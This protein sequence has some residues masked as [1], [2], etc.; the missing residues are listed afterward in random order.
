MKSRTMQ[1]VAMAALLIAVAASV[2]LAELGVVN[3]VDPYSDTIVVQA[4][5]TFHVTAI[6]SAEADK[7]LVVDLGDGRSGLTAAMGETIPV[8]YD[9]PGSYTITS[10]LGNQKLSPVTV[11]VHG[12]DVP[13][14][15]PAADPRVAL[16]SSSAS[17]GVGVGSVY[18]E[19]GKFPMRIAASGDCFFQ[20]KR[21]GHGVV[22]E[23]YIEAGDTI[24]VMDGPNDGEPIWTL[25]KFIDGE[26]KGGTHV[27]S[28]DSPYRLQIEDILVL[29]G[30]SY[31]PVGENVADTEW[32]LGTCHEAT[33][34]VVPDPW[35]A[36]DP[37]CAF[38]Y[39]W[40]G[41]DLTDSTG[42]KKEV[43]YDDGGVKE[44]YLDC[45]SDDTGGE[46]TTINSLKIDLDGM[47]PDAAGD[48]VDVDDGV[49]ADAGVLAVSQTTKLIV[50]R[51]G[52]GVAVGSYKLT[53]SNPSENKEL[54]IKREG[55][56][57]AGWKTSGHTESYDGSDHTYRIKLEA[58][59]NDPWLDTDTVM[60]T[61]THEGYN[62]TCED[63][64][65][66]VPVKVD[67]DVDA[68]YDGTISVDSPDDPIEVSAGGVV[69]V[70]SRTEISLREVMP[71][72]TASYGTLSWTT[73]KIKVFET[74]TGTSEVPSGDTVSLPGTLWVEGVSAS[75][76]A[77]DV[78]MT[79]E[80]ASGVKDEIAFTV[81]DVD[82]IKVRPY[83][84]GT[85]GSTA[86]IVVGGKTTSSH[87]HE[88]DVKFELYP[89]LP[90]GASVTLSVELQG[91]QG[92]PDDVHEAVLTVAG[93]TVTG[94]GS[95][96]VDFTSTTV[97][98]NLKS[99]NLTRDCTVL[100]GNASATVSFEWA[101]YTLWESSEEFIVI[102]SVSDETLTLEFDND[103][104]DS[105]K[106]RF[107]VEEVEYLNEEGDVAVLYNTIA[108]PGTEVNAYA[109]FTQN[110]QV[111]YGNGQVTTKL[112]IPATCPENIYSILMVAY[113]LS[114][115]AE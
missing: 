64:V 89:T 67:L 110:P 60:V 71:S 22:W 90:S 4:G 49:E 52:P 107:Y 7:K 93:T 114:A 26:Q 68:D 32:L 36:I 87:V 73:G 25:I 17:V 79:L 33:L 74:E 66:L 20:L 69:G 2:S 77:R 72:G 113:D 104:I 78:T 42:L 48:L 19:N 30:P 76:S 34:Q 39:N 112:H 45:D 91:A 102:D 94:N 18:A 109:Y 80:I 16:L 101:D 11:E 106:I 103:G 44:V 98:G 96:D 27:L 105:H 43:D 61:L 95:A 40:S 97:V 81:I 24:I 37:V 41:T 10:K 51:L 54:K 5:D 46:S 100:S 62:V 47:E 23:D 55:V 82:T 21:Y 29:E 14:D 6:H 8:R 12:T 65:K 70:G 99:S 50:R 31:A 86:S 85:Y 35:W 83:Q 63:K 13:A 115:N 15:V 88:A 59:G 75:D 9:V 3:L 111:T 84:S 1:P 108:L 38:L 92:D 53:W 57:G 56:A 58:P 28:P